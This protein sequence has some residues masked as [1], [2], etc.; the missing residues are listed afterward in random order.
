MYGQELEPRG[1]YVVA[2]RMGGMIGGAYYLT[3]TK[4]AL[5]STLRH[6]IHDYQHQPIITIAKVWSSTLV[7]PS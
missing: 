6:T 2:Y 5:P 3:T 7:P 4:L 1:E